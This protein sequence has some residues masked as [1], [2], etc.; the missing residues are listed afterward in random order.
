MNLFKEKIINQ[1]KKEPHRIGVFGVGVDKYWGQ[2]PGLYEE[3]MQKHDVLLK[4]LS[5]KGATIVNF[6]MVDNPK[7]AY[8]T[9]KKLEAANL[10]LVFCNMLTYA[11]SGTFG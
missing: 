11:T 7:K 6:G 3:L 2:F 10:D 8:E 9:V 4:K 1:T 5:T